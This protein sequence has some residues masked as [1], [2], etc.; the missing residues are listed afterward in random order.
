MTTYRP[1]VCDII[2]RWQNTC[3]EVKCLAA[4]FTVCAVKALK[5]DKADER[6]LDSPDLIVS[7]EQLAEARHAWTLT[8]TL[9]MLSEHL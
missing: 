4:H 8:C 9:L 7:L 6:T 5:P 3:I 2:E 1:Y